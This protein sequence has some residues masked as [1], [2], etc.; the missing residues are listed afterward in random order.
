MKIKKKFQIIALMTAS[1]F[2]LSACASSTSNSST[3]SSN[4]TAANA[5]QVATSFYPLT[6]LVKEIGG[7]KVAITDLTPPGSDAH[8]AELAPADI[9]KLQ[10]MDLVIYLD[11]FAPA[12]DEAIETS[13]LK[14]VLEIG[15]SVNLLEQEEVNAF[16]T[17]LGTETEHAN[18]T[19]EEH[20]EHSEEEADHDHSTETA[21]EHAD[22]DHGTHD[23][24]FWTDPARLAQAA[25]VVAA[26]LA[27]ISPENSELFTNN[28]TAVTEKLTKLAEG[29]KTTL[30]SKQCQTDAFIVTHLAFGYLALEN[31]LKQIGI[32]GIDPE[33]EPSP[34]R[35]AQIKE[36]AEHYKVSTIF[37]TS[38]AE[39]KAA[40]TVAAETGTKVEVLDPAA[41]QRDTNKDYAQVME[42][43]FKLLS[44]AL[45][46]K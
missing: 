43:N 12:I 24:H 28:A 6:Y 38:D 31:N 20:A 41:T 1:A 21:E 25:P 3:S 26:E 22:H 46:C 33:T 35:I 13:D 40:S 37:T 34:A 23:P 9:A 27:K 17:N 19:A 5:V 30:A 7:D 15:Q 39:K 14:N 36:A 8:G 44:T 29:F 18:E 16:S 32:A 11:T 10:K 45:G 4:T 42:E 2:A